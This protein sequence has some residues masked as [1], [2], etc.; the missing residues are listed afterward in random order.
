MEALS[1]PIRT[2]KL[3]LVGHTEGDCLYVHCTY[4]EEEQPK[5]AH[6]LWHNGVQSRMVHGSWLSNFLHVTT[7]TGLQW[8]TV[9]YTRLR[10]F[11]DMAF[12]HIL[13]ALANKNFEELNVAL[14]TQY[15]MQI[16]NDASH[17]PVHPGVLS[18]VYSIE[19][20]IIEIKP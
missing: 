11:G 10:Q 5:I 13:N 17:L 8:P 6:S 1:T 19:P 14:Q 2:A 12:G 9:P 16:V 15:G 7:M 4:F 3:P 18:R 20:F